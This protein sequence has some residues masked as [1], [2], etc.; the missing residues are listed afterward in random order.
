MSNLSCID[1]IATS[2]PTIAVT[3]MVNGVPRTES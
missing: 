3:G 1:M 2:T